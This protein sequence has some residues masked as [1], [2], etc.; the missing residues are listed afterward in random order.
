MALRFK[1]QLVVVADD[2]QVSV[3]EV[4]ALNKEPE[5]LEHLGLSWLRPKRSCWKC[6]AKC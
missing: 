4:V 3:D 6:S 1:L 2:E 5:R